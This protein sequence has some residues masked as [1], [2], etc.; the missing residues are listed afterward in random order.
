M[1]RGSDDDIYDVTKNMIT[2]KK[3]REKEDKRE[4]KED[5]T[6]KQ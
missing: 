1:Q 6:Q 4:R 5:K 3:Q 2:T